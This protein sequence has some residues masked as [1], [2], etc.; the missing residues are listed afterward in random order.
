VHFFAYLFIFEFSALWNK[1][2]C[3]K[4]QVLENSVHLFLLKTV[5]NGQFSPLLPPAKAGK[6]QHRS[7]EVKS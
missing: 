5:K 1:P 2:N 4:L 7:Q 3:E 6:K